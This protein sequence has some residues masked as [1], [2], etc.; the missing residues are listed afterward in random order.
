LDGL[1]NLIERAPGSADVENVAAV[2]REH[3]AAPG[4]VA[5]AEKVAGAAAGKP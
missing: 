1:G 3:F 4:K 5:G 2:V